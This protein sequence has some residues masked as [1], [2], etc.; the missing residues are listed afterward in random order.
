MTT[1]DL[2]FIR[3]PTKMYLDDKNGSGMRELN[4]GKITSMFYQIP[5][6]DYINYKKMTTGIESENMNGG[7]IGN[8]LSKIP[9]IGPLLFGKG[10]YSSD[11]TDLDEIDLNGQGAFDWHDPTEEDKILLHE[12]RGIEGNS[13]F[14][15]VTGQTTDGYPIQDKMYRGNGMYNGEGMEGGFAFASL[16]PLIPMAVDLVK[17]L[18]SGSKSDGEGYEGEGISGVNESILKILENDSPVYKEILFKDDKGNLIKR[19][20]VQMTKLGEKMIEDQDFLN[21]LADLNGV[22]LQE[23]KEVGRKQLAKIRFPAKLLSALQQKFDVESTDKNKSKVTAFHEDDD[24]YTLGPPGTS[25][26]R[27]LSEQDHRMRDWLRDNPHA[28]SS[29]SGSTRGSINDWADAS[30]DLLAN[31]IQ[32]SSAFLPRQGAL[33]QYS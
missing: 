6:K 10:M 24:G 22:P 12:G 16:I 32:R 26:A 7:F 30:R 15:N 5:T 19:E 18:F 27:H 1:K 11:A 14:G 23:L 2:K 28:L 13:I 29:D 25:T 33:W 3:I 20:M 9:I 21:E 31:P 4:G 17:G 8:L